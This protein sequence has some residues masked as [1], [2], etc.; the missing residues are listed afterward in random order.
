LICIPWCCELL[1]LPDTGRAN[2]AA[3]MLDL[4][5]WLQCLNFP[6][7]FSQSDWFSLVTGTLGSGFNV[8]A[9]N[10][11][12][13]LANVALRQNQLYQKKNYNLTWVAVARDDIRG[14]MSISLNRINNYMLVAVFVFSVAANALFFVQSF[15]SS[16]PDFV[17][18]SFW[19][20]TGL[21]IAFLSL[22][23]M[24]GIKGQSSAFVNTMR[25]LTWELRPENPAQMDH[26]YL[27]Q[28]YKFEEEGTR[29]MMRIPGLMKAVF[30]KTR[31]DQNETAG[32]RPDSPV[33]YGTSLHEDFV[34]QRRADEKMI[35]QLDPETS[36]LLYL[37][38]FVNY[39][40]LWLPYESN[41]KYCIGLG[42]IALSQGGAYFSLGVL[43]WG[44]LSGGFLMALEMIIVFVSI[45]IMI[46]QQNYK[47]KNLYT[48]LAAIGLFVAGPAFAALGALIED[49]PWVRRVFAPLTCLGHAAL[50]LGIFLYSFVQTKDPSY[51]T[52]QYTVGPHGQQFTRDW[53]DGSLLQ[54][55]K[56][57]RSKRSTKDQET[58]EDHLD[59]DVSDAPPGR[60]KRGRSR[61]VEGRPIGARS[62]EAR[63]RSKERGRWPLFGGHQ[64]DPN[65]PPAV[66]F[67]DDSALEED[68]KSQAVQARS[69]RSIRIMLFVAS[70]LW[71]ALFCLEIA[72]AISQS[73]AGTHYP[74]LD[75]KN[76]QIDWPRDASG[77]VSLA[78]AQAGQLYASNRFQVFQISP[79]Q[80][81]VVT[82]PCIGLD[83]TI[84]D[85]S[86]A[87]LGP[88]CSLTV[89]VANTSTLINCSSGTSSQLRP[90]EPATRFTISASV[91]DAVPR[92]TMLALH[93][94]FVMEY[95]WNVVGRPLGWS[96][97]NPRT[98][99][100]SSSLV[101]MDIHQ[102]Q[103][104]LFGRSSTDGVVWLDI[105]DLRSF[106]SRSQWS[107]PKLDDP[108]VAGCA[109]ANG[110]DVWF[111]TGG[112]VPKL[113]KATLL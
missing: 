93:G 2:S 12:G 37:G 48:A 22:A 38:R 82:R 36:E 105:R 3:Y 24:F 95:G 65:P 87:C 69:A 27:Q 16:C 10:Q 92:S 96:P 57:G 43:S 108:F 90:S 100:D 85:V 86:A 51:F 49:P 74:L 40:Q 91:L 58:G 8:A 25:L 31:K 11:T 60:S 97:L 53:R 75:L 78:C 88:D 32:E 52:R 71:F 59:F 94:S 54:N 26:D 7:G 107:L 66:K 113:F 35:E 84:A 99:V 44:K 103:L 83:Q 5:G 63:A 28:A 67:Q 34:A 45:T 101:N 17:L 89:L 98:D 47:P 81:K 21:C 68:L 79:Y 106:V 73:N 56:Q 19:L 77:L 20:C 76:V 50:Y 6:G 62:S 61:S 42:F 18:N 109:D 70:T 14:M 30:P 104:Y 80:G 29:E 110:H 64:S 112:T 15:D 102:Q 41:C 4:I 33:V 39:M 13:Y 1:P 55:K 9:Y 72:S 111:L 46:Y 23:I